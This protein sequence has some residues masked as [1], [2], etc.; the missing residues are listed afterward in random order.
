MTEIRYPDTVIHGV[1]VVATP[2]EIDITNAGQLFAALLDAAR[3][4]HPVIVADMTG[5]RFCD[6]TGLYALI[7]AHR[8]AQAEGSELHLV[9]P[10]NG[11]VARVIALTALDT[12][13]P[14]FSSLEEA[15]AGTP[16]ETEGGTHAD[17]APHQSGLASAQHPHRRRMRSTWRP[18]MIQNIR[19]TG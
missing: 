6:S 9:I 3:T 19:G 13:I 2:A 11:A 7:T 4:W 18:A 14:C 15:L 10:A 17:R 16:D 1:P 8:R 5:T 12:F